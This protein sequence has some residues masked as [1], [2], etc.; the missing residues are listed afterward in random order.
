MSKRNK[1]ST[2]K[3]N[4]GLQTVNLGQLIA[5][6]TDQST[7]QFLYA[8]HAQFAVTDKEVYIDLYFVGLSPNSY[9]QA[10]A[11]FLQRVIIPHALAKGFATGL[12]NAV[13]NYETGEGVI[14]PNQRQ[15]S[16][17]DKVTIWP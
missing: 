16:L 7:G 13:A 2:T 4:R 14:F 8:N 11:R 17:D 3:A 1:P 6:A 15:P 10:E 12:A 5:G 9:T